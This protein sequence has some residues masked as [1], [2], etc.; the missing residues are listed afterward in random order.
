MIRIKHPSGSQELSV[1]NGA[2]AQM[3]KP[4]GWTPVEPPQ[5]EQSVTEEAEPE[6]KVRRKPR[7]VKK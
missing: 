6:V 4:L 1:S 3:Y 2:Y 7:T 5:P